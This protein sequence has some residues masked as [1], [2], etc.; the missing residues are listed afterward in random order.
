MH[1]HTTKLK[2]KKKKSFENILERERVREKN[3]L[4]IIDRDDYIPSVGPSP[5]SFVKKIF[6]SAFSK[7]KSLLHYYTNWCGESVTYRRWKKKGTEDFRRRER[8]SSFRIVVFVLFSVADSIARLKSLV[9]FRLVDKETDLRIPQV[10]IDLTSPPPPPRR[11]KTCTAINTDTA[12]LWKPTK[13]RQGK[14]G[15]F[16]LL[17]S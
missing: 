15:M 8:K 3:V 1:H 4:L 13:R 7:G 16:R 17:N 6:L 5:P 2:Q 12:F 10:I 14:L 11:R 9:I